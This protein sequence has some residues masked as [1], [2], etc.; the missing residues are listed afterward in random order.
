MKIETK[1]LL[2]LVLFSLFITFL[3][4]IV[5]AE[6]IMPNINDP[7]GIGL[8]TE[9]IVN[10]GDNPEATANASA[11]YL[12]QEWKKIID[13]KLPF[14]C[15]SHNFLLAHQLP[16]EIVFKKDYS[17]TWAFFLTLALWL[18][19]A[20]FLSELF[21]RFFSSKKK[22]GFIV[23]ILGAII[24]AQINI[25]NWIVNGTL[26]LINSPEAWW[27]R[28]LLGVVIITIFILLVYFKDALAD[29]FKAEEKERKEQETE[30]KL[31][32]LEE[33]SKGR[34]EGR[35]LSKPLR[36]ARE[37]MSHLGEGI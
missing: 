5:Y 29:L 36:K 16:F 2:S 21:N 33:E 32:E 15:K 1:I 34:E 18:W 9:K 14:L 7:L 8:D 30:E 4:L 13:E 26:F 23:G 25:L 10:A 3:A 37:D 6:E 12:K 28:G 24:F 17:F 22:F 27:M 20:S 31:E 11:N 35:E 19:S